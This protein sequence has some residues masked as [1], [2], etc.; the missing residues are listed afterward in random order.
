MNF[1]KPFFVICK[2]QIWFNDKKFI[3]LE[4]LGRTRLIKFFFMVCI[5]VFKMQNTLSYSF[6]L[7]ICLLALLFIAYWP[8]SFWTILYQKY[9]AI[10]LIS[11]CTISGSFDIV[12]ITYSCFSHFTMGLLIYKFSHWKDKIVFYFSPQCS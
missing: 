2:K 7:L 10:L 5:A 6:S 11:S 1:S 12:P 3:N 9:F 4:T 8:K